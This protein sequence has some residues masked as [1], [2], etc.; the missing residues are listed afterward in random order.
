MKQISIRKQF[1]F[2]SFQIQNN[3]QFIQYSNHQATLDKSPPI[4]N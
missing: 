1:Q 3:S 4:F 2:L